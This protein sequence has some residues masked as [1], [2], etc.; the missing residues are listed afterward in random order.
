MVSLGMWVAYLVQSK[1]PGLIESAQ[2][3]NSTVWMKVAANAWAY[4]KPNVGVDPNTGLPYAGGTT[5]TGFTDWDL[6]VYIQA[7]IDAQK[8]GLIGND[9]AWGSNARIDKVLTFLETRDLNNNSY[10]YQF[11]DATTGKDDSTMSGP[12]IV[13]IVDTGRLFVALNNLINFNSSLAARV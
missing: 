9:G 6:G 10:P 11:Y 13:D 4:F 5:F 2:T 8:I 1:P 3:L 12:E 7:I